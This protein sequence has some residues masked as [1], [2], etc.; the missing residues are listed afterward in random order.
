MLDNAS[1]AILEEL[2]TLIN[3]QI[4]VFG[5]EEAAGLPDTSLKDW[6]KDEPRTYLDEL[7]KGHAEV[8]IWYTYPFLYNIILPLSREQAVV[9][10]C[11]GP[12]PILPLSREQAYMIA[13][14]HGLAGVV[15]DE[16]VSRICS[17]IPMD[18]NSIISLARLSYRLLTGEA[19]PEELL[20]VK[21]EDTSRMDIEPA[22][23]ELIFHQR[24]SPGKRISLRYE[25]EFLDRV[26]SGSLEALAGLT[27]SDGG[28]VGTMSQ[29]PLNQAKYTLVSLVTLLARAAIDSGVED[30]MAF[31]LSDALCQRMDAMK[32]PLSVNAVAEEAV[33]LFTRKIG[34]AKQ[35]RRYS[36]P[37]QKVCDYISAHLHDDL[38]NLHLADI[39]QL[40]PRSMSQRFRDEVGMKISQ[41]INL[42]RINEAKL[43]LKHSDY[44]L[45][46][47]AQYLHY[48]TQS[49]FTLQFRQH[50]GMTPQVYRESFQ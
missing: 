42:Q 7:K 44:D 33:V 40:S 49:Y 29:N 37:I 15:A 16:F 18:Y 19:L 26:C 11:I 4:L 22:I 2:H 46:D 21:F 8:T 5:Q 25:K 41:Y 36:P 34:E 48:S 50:T 24:E 3:A 13:G 47:I 10:V 23:S 31:S 17:V 39:A 27:G 43:L 12:L 30:E 45:C 14:G 35:K 9:V 1:W 28:M 20:K 38:S 6:Y 32:D